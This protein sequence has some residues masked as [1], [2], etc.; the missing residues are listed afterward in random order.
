MFFTKPASS[1]MREALRSV[2]VDSSWV[3]LASERGHYH[4]WAKFTRGS[5]QWDISMITNSPR[6]E[7]DWQVVRVLNQIIQVIP[8]QFR[9]GFK[10]SL[11]DQP[12]Q[13]FPLFLQWAW[14]G[15]IAKVVREKKNEMASQKWLG[16]NCPTFQEWWSCQVDNEELEPKKNKQLNMYVMHCN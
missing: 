7:N 6:T 9:Q 8:R 1:A 15:S 14:N 11:I 4:L 12:M 13:N 5:A 2:L 3:R 16:G 10:L